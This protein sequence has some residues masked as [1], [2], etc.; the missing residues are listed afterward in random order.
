MRYTYETNKNFFS[1]PFVLKTLNL[2]TQASIPASVPLFREFL[3]LLMDPNPKSLVHLLLISEDIIP[4]YPFLHELF[5]NE[6]FVKAFYDDIA[7]F[8]A[9]PSQ[10][11][12]AV[13]ATNAVRFY[14]IM[15]SRNNIEIETVQ[16]KG[17][18]I[19][20][21]FQIFCF[22]LSSASNFN[23][24][25]TNSFLRSI[26]DLHY[27]LLSSNEA[28]SL[29]LESLVVFGKSLLNIDPSIAKIFLKSASSLNL[30]SYFALLSLSLLTH[31]SEPEFIIS[32]FFEKELYQSIQKEHDFIFFYILKDF[33]IQLFLA[34]TTTE[35]QESLGFLILKLLPRFVQN[36]Y[37]EILK[38][39]CLLFSRFSDQ[40]LKAHLKTIF[41][42][43]NTATSSFDDYYIL[44]FDKLISLADPLAHY[45][46]QVS[47]IVSFFV[48]DF[49]A[50]SN[51]SKR[52]FAS[53]FKETVSS[54][55][56]FPIIFS[57]IFVIYQS[58]GNESK[59]EQIAEKVFEIW[60]SKQTRESTSYAFSALFP[61]NHS[62]TTTAD[63]ILQ[64]FL[65]SLSI[66]ITQTESEEDLNFYLPCTLR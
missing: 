32:L 34:K 58:S 14:R 22:A 52:F 56:D 31:F 36:Q 44:F 46:V 53:L 47:N 39:F 26:S 13:F 19:L 40:F 42:Y 28:L 18:S 45:L 60:L 35:Q 1:V 17:D 9:R 64:K 66:L 33:R 55:D 4:E 10:K 54:S 51:V 21:Y 48:C 20:I 57:S 49:E 12:T 6:L 62:Y 23:Q 24:N 15:I 8:F 29:H 61:I 25:L 63:A 3:I 41:L 59:Y 16:Q 2:F 38:L 27:I 30:N 5:N 43:L 37:N 11:E 65:S 7:Q 50:H